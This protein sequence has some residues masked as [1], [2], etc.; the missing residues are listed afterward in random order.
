MSYFVVERDRKYLDRAQ[1][2]DAKGNV[3]FDN[4]LSMTYDQMKSQRDLDDFVL[5][6]MDAANVNW[7]C[8]DKDTV[9]TL[10]G[11]DNLFIW[12]IV[13]HPGDNDK[14]Q[15]WFVDWKKDGKKYRYT[16]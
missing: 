15:Y 6:I 9:V 1:I 5:A 3:T 8:D 7:N 4:Y 2:V 16:P 12:S 14:I 11:E 10:I 13:I